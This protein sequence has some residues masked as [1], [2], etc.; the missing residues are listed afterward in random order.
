M[1]GLGL[2]ASECVVEDLG[3]SLA[4]LQVLRFRV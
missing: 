3:R 2:G 4:G 1:W